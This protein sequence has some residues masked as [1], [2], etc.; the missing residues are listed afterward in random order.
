MSRDKSELSAFRT[1]FCVWKIWF[2][3]FMPNVEFDQIETFTIF[4]SLNLESVVFYL[5]RYT[6]KTDTYI[7]AFVSFER[8]NKV[9][10][11]TFGSIYSHIE[12]RSSS[13]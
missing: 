2:F 6:E 13:S 3:Y 1:F 7:I 12:W 8:G 4:D 9:K 5:L 11:L 10:A